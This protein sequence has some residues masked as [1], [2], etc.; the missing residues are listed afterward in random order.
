MFEEP[1][2][3]LYS[4]LAVCL[5][6]ETE[7]EKNIVY[8]QGAVGGRH[9]ACVIMPEGVRGEGNERRI[10]AHVCVV[11]EM[12]IRVLGVKRKALLSSD[13]CLLF[14]FIIR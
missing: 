14:L 3:T 12:W 7:I 5:V 11:L 8:Y 4:F 10:G 1:L 9:L 6:R 2:Q 13:L